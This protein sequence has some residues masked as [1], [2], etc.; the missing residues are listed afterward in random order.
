VSLPSDFI[1]WTASDEAKFLKGKIVFANWDVNQLK[2]RKEEILKERG[3]LYISFGGFPQRSGDNVRV[4]P[5]RE[6]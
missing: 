3:E 5:K 1:V 2:T 4:V 6:S